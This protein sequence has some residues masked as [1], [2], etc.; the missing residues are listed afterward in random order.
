MFSYNQF[1]GSLFD[2]Y[3]PTRSPNLKSIFPTLLLIK[4]ILPLLA[5]LK[6]QLARF[7][8]GTLKNLHFLI[9]HE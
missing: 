7:C 1:F 2:T 9:L 3:G 8:S 5:L 4:C 6:T